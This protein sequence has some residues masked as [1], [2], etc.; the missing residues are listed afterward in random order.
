M[1]Q[2]LGLPS[3]LLLLLRIEENDND[4]NNCLLML[5]CYLKSPYVLCVG[6]L[7]H[8]GAAFQVSCCLL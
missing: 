4:E 3:L 8:S 6:E 1:D 5:R 7:V 2:G